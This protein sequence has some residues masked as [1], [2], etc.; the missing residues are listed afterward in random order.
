M[1][2]GGHVLHE[3]NHAANPTDGQQMVDNVLKNG[4]SKKKFMAMLQAQGVSKTNVKAMFKHT[5]KDTLP[6]GL[7]VAQYFTHLS[8]SETGQG[9]FVTA[10]KQVFIFVLQF[11]MCLLSQLRTWA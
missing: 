7:P 2:P 3:M 5:K 9:S 11:A 4:A 6:P 8:T 1:L 10:P